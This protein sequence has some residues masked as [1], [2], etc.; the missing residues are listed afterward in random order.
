MIEALLAIIAALGLALGLSR[1]ANERAARR[2]AA[3]E[4]RA[5]AAESQAESLA[6]VEIARGRARQAGQD[7]LAAL[8]DQL[9]SGRRDQLERP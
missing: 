8:R 2:A 4:A 9:A 7:E 6:R 1:R 5:A 3:A